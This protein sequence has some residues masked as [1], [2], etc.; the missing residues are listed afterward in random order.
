MEGIGVIMA[1]LQATDAPN[2]EIAEALRK[3]DA[4]WKFA[5]KAFTSEQFVPNGP[6]ISTI[7]AVTPN[8][9]S[10]SSMRCPASTQVCTTTVY[11]LPACAL[12]Q[13]ARRDITTP[14]AVR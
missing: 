7:V 8:P 14:N 11:K 4:R 6:P 12:E 1:E 3:T 5:S 2:A 9:C 10:V 13:Q